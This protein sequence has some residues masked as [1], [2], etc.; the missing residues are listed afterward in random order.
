MESVPSSPSSDGTWADAA[1]PPPDSLSHLL[2]MAEERED[3]LPLT[4]DHEADVATLADLASR[5]SQLPPR[6]D[7]EDEDAINAL[8]DDLMAFHRKLGADSRVMTSNARRALDDAGA[9]ATEDASLLAA[10]VAALSAEDPK[11]PAAVNAEAVRR[12]LEWS[13]DDVRRRQHA[14]VDVAERSAGLRAEALS[15]ALGAAR[16]SPDPSP[17]PS[18]VKPS[19]PGTSPRSRILS[20]ARKL[21]PPR[22]VPASP[23]PSSSPASRAS[24]TSSLDNL[25]DRHLDE[26]AHRNAKARGMD[27]PTITM[28]T[29]TKHEGLKTV[30]L[31]DG[32]DSRAVSRLDADAETRRATADSALRSA[33][34]PL[35]SAD[36]PLRS[37]NSPSPSADSPSGSDTTPSERDAGSPDSETS[38]RRRRLRRRVLRDLLVAAPA[39]VFSLYD[40]LRPARAKGDGG[41]RRARSRLATDPRPRREPR[42]VT[43]RELDRETAGGASTAVDS[44]GSGATVM[45]VGAT[46]YEVRD[47]RPVAKPTPAGTRRYAEE[48]QMRKVYGMG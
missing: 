22:A 44:V 1:G 43:R 9:R 29:P 24:T 30:R 31:V 36:S 35:R 6:A 11:D 34:S 18:P 42:R 17:D 3:L 8:F 21:P 47:G 41:R 19:F 46:E 26:Q 39:L 5:A 20:P 28:F 33:D 7:D 45:K 27:V 25:I 38:R 32:A 10:A 48:L 23:S 37:A 40:A 16:D 2:A 12:R 4:G 15:H 13:L 14:A